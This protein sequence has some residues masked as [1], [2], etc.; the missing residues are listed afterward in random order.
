MDNANE[1][2]AVSKNGTAITKA[3]MDIWEKIGQPEDF[4]GENGKAL[5]KEIANVYTFFFRKDYLF[6]LHD[7]NMDLKFEKSIE[8]LG[9]ENYGYNPITYPPV[10]LQMIKAMFP[11]A[12]MS[13]RRTQK[14]MVEVIPWLKTTNLRI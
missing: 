8:Q 12:N 13:S 14:V 4:Y 9:R 3:L 2:E 11:D 7:R 10:L 5:L 6:F 1:Y